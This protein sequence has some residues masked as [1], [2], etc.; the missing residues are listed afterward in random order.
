[1]KLGKNAAAQALGSL[2]GKARAAKLSKKRRSEIA[3]IAATA[4]RKPRKPLAERCYCGKST[5]LR[6]KL[7]SFN[8]CKKAGKFT[9]Q[10][11]TS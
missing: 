5:L 9:T 3:S 10:K 2:G 4:P 6:A 7:Q 11:K 8:C 1:M